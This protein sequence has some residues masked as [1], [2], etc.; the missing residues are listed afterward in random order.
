MSGVKRFEDIMEAVCDLCRWPF[1][2]EDADFELML[3]EKCGNCPAEKVLRE[4]MP[5][6]I[7]VKERLPET[8]DHVLCC[9]VT[10]AGKRNVVRGY[11]CL[12]TQVWAS[13]MNANVTHWMPM[14]W[15]PMPEAP[16]VEV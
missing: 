2:Y 6:W 1:E 10:K 9:T 14:P 4:N 5:Q 15:M 7:S 12:D 13:G 11:Y 16:E 8:E 3:D